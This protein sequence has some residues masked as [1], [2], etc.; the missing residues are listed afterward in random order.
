MDPAVEQAPQSVT[1]QTELIKR[2]WSDAVWSARRPQS[3][4]FE[5][6]PKAAACLTPACRPDLWLPSVRR[7][8]VP[9][10]SAPS[11]QE[12]KPLAFCFRS[13]ARLYREIP[14]W[15]TASAQ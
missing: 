3:W 13:K 15:A 4:L 8:K 14:K 5:P 2:A 6:P 11:H 10:L 7:T 1:T 9:T 12:K